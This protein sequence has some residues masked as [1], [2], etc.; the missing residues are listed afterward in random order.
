MCVTDVSETTLRDSV[1]ILRSVA[2]QAATTH[3]RLIS[4]WHSSSVVQHS[5]LQPRAVQKSVKTH[6]HTC[7]WFIDQWLISLMAQCQQKKTRPDRKWHHFFLAP[8]LLVDLLEV[9]SFVTVLITP[10][11]TVCFMSRIAKRPDRQR[12]KQ[13]FIYW[14]VFMYPL[15]IYSR[16]LRFL[17]SSHLMSSNSTSSHFISSNLSSSH[18]IVESERVMEDNLCQYSQIP[19]RSR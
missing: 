7:C 2:W 16:H 3:T 19:C 6:G 11:A 10:T 4:C 14:C 1:L 17:L 8:A 15:L 13:M 18:I 12:S 5:D 9:S